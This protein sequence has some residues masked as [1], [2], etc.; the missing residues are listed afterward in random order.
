MA[1]LTE[2]KKNLKPD[3]CTQVRKI[4]EMFRHI[5]LN[6]PDAVKAAF[7]LYL[8]NQPEDK[9]NNMVAFYEENAQYL[10]RLFDYR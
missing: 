7:G 9:Q 3:D 6:D 5:C 4:L 10:A 8:R 1:T 2:I